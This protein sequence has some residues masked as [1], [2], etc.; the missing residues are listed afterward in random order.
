MV[1]DQVLRPSGQ[2][3]DGGF[4]RV[5]AQLAIESCQHL[6]KVDGPLNDLAAKTIRLPNDLARLHATAS[7]QGAANLRPMVAASVLVN[8]GCPSK[9]APG[10]DGHILVEAPLVQIF[11]EGAH[12]LVEQRAVRV[13]ELGEVVAV[14]IP[15]TEVERD[16]PRTR[17]DQPASDEKVF[18][19]ARRTIAI[20]PRVALAVSLAD[21]GVFSRD[22]QASAN[23]LDVSTPSAC[24]VNASCPSSLP[25]ESTSRR[26]RSMLESNRR[27]SLSRSALMPLSVRSDRPSP[28]GRNATLGRTKESR[29]ARRAVWRVTGLRRQTDKRRNRLVLW[30]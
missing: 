26:M 20:V 15:A 23:L 25:L 28:L 10:D 8:D 5:D 11:D 7:E 17:F 30:P 2:V 24:W 13:F 21:L 22:V 27:R 16:T 12:S 1:I 19:I 3:A 29:M 6:P 9:F 14:E 18:Q 4:V